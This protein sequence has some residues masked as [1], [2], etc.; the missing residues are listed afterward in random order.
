MT[1]PIGDLDIVIEGGGFP[2][3][4]QEV[5]EDLVAIPVIGPPGPKGDDGYIG[6]DGAMGPQGP[7]GPKGPPDGVEWFFGD[8]PPE[9]LILGAK[10]GDK[11]LDNLSGQIYTLNE[12]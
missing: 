1:D 11:Y 2:S 9:G 5:V 8:G 7:R 3:E 10:V 6:R 4:I 12:G